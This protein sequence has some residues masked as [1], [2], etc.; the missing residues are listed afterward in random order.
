[1]VGEKNLNADHYTDGWPRDDD[2]S[3]YV[4]FDNDTCRTTILAPKQ[5]TPGLEWMSF[6]SVHPGG[7]HVAMCDGSVQVLSYNL[8]GA[9]HR[10]LGNR[11]DGEAAS[12]NP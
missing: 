9:V 11:G 12:I 7:W 10:R 1:M 8:D 3:V 2:D 5:D 4:G 6:G